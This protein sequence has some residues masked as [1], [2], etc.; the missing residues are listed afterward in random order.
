M[1]ERYKD[2]HHA[3]AWD[4]VVS[5]MAG[6]ENAV[7]MTRFNLPTWL[8]ISR[9]GAALLIPVAYLV[10]DRPLADFVALAIFAI[11]AVTDFVDGELARR[12]RLESR[13]GAA[14][15][16]VADKA[17]VIVA[18]AV[19]L[20]YADARAALLLPVA[21][22]LVRELMVSG[23][24]EYLGMTTPTVLRVTWTAK[25]KTACQMTA[26][27]LLFLSA[28]AGLTGHIAGLMGVAALW[29]AAGL[30]VI[31]GL[32]YLRKALHAI[33]NDAH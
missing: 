31:S 22:I 15:D 6:Q 17:M 16:P 25:I 4:H 9:F 7:C 19:L 29:L 28:S 30:T 14:L 20:A 21:V 18:L 26:I 12:M 10:F 24:R 11:G 33:E 5:V 32:D 27:I 3:R 2:F 23:M 8:T 13:L 1:W